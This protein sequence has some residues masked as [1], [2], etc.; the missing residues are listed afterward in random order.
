[1]RIHA[2]STGTVVI[3]R[4]VLKTPAVYLPS[5]NPD[6]AQRLA[7]RSVASAASVPAE[8]AAAT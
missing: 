6:A 1:M 7:A 8:M 4:F 3:K 2:V 5:H